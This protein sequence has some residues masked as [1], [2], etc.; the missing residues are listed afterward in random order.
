MNTKK[1]ATLTIGREFLF[2]RTAK[3]LGEDISRELRLMTA[4]RGAVD[5]GLVLVACDPGDEI[6]IQRAIM[7]SA[8]WGRLYE[9]EPLQFFHDEDVLA[10]ALKLLRAARGEAMTHELHDR[11]T[12]FLSSLSP[13]PL[14][15]REEK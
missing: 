14:A 5:S 4:K 8:R 10:K 13:D 2:H 9:G 11:I 1:I 3:D 7:D 15:Q 6:N 12:A